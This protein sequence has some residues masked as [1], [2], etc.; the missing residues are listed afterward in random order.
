M[1]AGSA[2]IKTHP[3]LTYYILTLRSQVF[4]WRVGARWYAVALLTGP[5]VGS[6]VTFGLSLRDAVFLPGIL[7]SEHKVSLVLI[8]IAVG[9]SAGFLEELGWTGFAVSRLRRRHS[10]LV[11]GLLVGFLWGAWHLPLFSGQRSPSGIPIAVYLSVLCFSFLPPFRVLMVWLYDRT[12]SVLIVMIMHAALSATSL[13]LQPQTAGIEVVVYD[14]AFAA[15]LWVAVAVVTAI[16][17]RQNDGQAAD[18]VR[19]AV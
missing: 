18:L 17:P 2:F 7:I 1:G 12:E 3:V 11:T 4:N 8:G 15:A 10:V 19:I 16:D 6:A 5:L 14:L 9:A 13:I